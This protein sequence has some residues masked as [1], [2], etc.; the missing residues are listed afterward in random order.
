MQIITRSKNVDVAAFLRSFDFADMPG[1]GFSFSCDADGH[2]DV[3]SLKPLQRRSY[4]ACMSGQIAVTDYAGEPAQIRRV[5]DCGVLDVSYS[6]RE[7]AIGRCS[8]GADVSL[9]GFTNTC[10]CG[11]DYNSAGQHLAPREQWGEETGE[12]AAD[13]LR[14]GD[15]FGEDY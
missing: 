6:Y 15:A 2:V 9:D 11:A 10:R 14:G 4:D 7:P 3:A 5:I 12:T 1:S 13:I 8:C